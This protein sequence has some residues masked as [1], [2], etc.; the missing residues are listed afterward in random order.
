[1]FEQFFL[2]FLIGFACVLLPVL[3]SL[4][5]FRHVRLDRPPIGVFNGQDIVILLCV[6][7]AL[8][9]LYLAIPALLLTG[10][11]VLTFSS[12]LFNIL[13]PFLSLLL[14]WLIILVLL[15][16]NIVV[17]ITIFHSPIGLILYWLSNSVIVGLGAIG[18]ANLYVQGGMRLRHAAWFALGL[19]FYDG[20][21]FLVIPI[22]PRL[23]AAFVGH[24]LIPAAGFLSGN[25]GISMG[26]GDLFMY[27]LFA[28][29][30][31]KGFG[32]KGIFTSIPIIV[33]FGFIVPLLSSV[34]FTAFL[35]HG[36]MPGVPAQVFFGPAAFLT[37]LWLS[38]HT[39]ER[40]MF[41]WYQV[42]EAA[43]HRIIRV[44]RRTRPQAIR[45][46]SS[47]TP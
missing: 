11:L 8:P 23:N 24:P 19:A 4:W 37:Y 17:T 39:P 16:F 10:F 25:A 44:R 27:C 2:P 18:V 28:V 13:R 38:R 22:T 3:G 31:Y 29:A 20:F 21:F 12:A 45:N 33:L 26:L 46:T 5:F 35:Q 32:R 30:A 42:Q 43:G 47:F 41:E 1:M 34:L 40:R 6:V 9:F 7:T 14:T 15:G 36:N